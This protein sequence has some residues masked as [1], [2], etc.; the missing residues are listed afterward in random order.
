M[1]RL[2][3]LLATPR[4]LLRAL[5]LC[6]YDEVERSRLRGVHY[7]SDV[8][9]RGAERITAGSNVFIDHRAYLHAGSV[10]DRRGF[11]ALGNDIEIGPYSVLW[12]GGGITIGNNVH[13]G[14]H[15]HITSQQG[16][17]LPRGSER[18]STDIRIGCAPVTIGDN[19]LIYSGAIIVPGVTVGSHAS[20]AAGAVVIDDVPEG[21]L[22]AGVPARIIQRAVTENASTIASRPVL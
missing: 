8:I 17:H 16:E 4:A 12:G 6:T 19:V 22:V 7:G 14:A 15:V 2:E 3:L 11:I 5:R 20:I 13:M 10:N 9:V 21:A 1:R 18:E